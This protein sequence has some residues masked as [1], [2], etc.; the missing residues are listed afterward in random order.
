M[1]DTDSDEE[2]SVLIID[3]GSCMTKVGFSG[4]D[5]PRAV[6][7]TVVGHPKIKS[8]FTCSK[9]Y[10]VGDEAD[11]MQGI[12]NMK[13]MLERGYV[14]DWEDMERIWYHT[15]YNELRVAPEQH[16]VLLA[17]TS[18]SSKAC[19]EKATQIMF[20]TFKI[21]SFYLANQAVLAL[22]ACGKDTGIVVNSGDRI[23]EIVPVYEGVVI[24]HAIKT[25]N[26][27]GQRVTNHL[28]KILMERGH[29]LTT[30]SE[31]LIVKDIKEKMCYV[32]LDFDQEMSIAASSTNFDRSYVLPEGNPISIGNQLFRAPEI[33][34]R[35]AFP[36]DESQGLHETIYDSIM[37]CDASIRRHLFENCV[38]AGG[39]TMFPG[40]AE[41]IHKELYSLGPTTFKVKVIAPPERKY[42][43][44][45]GGSILSSLS[46]FPDV[47]IRKEEY[48]ETGP[49]IIHRKCP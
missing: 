24:P 30:N 1:S 47:C 39:N 43:V 27:A 9:D 38:L 10:Y 19:R 37:S 7:P 13:Y 11:A 6:F 48:E 45:I 41:R 22:N 2:N 49:N 26:F 12:L 5:A 20:E 29:S 3:N 21:P 46:K 31:R 18:F 44:W 14:T 34:F 42:S 40:L 32:A 23:T 33:L 28:S 35:P 36:D 15:F 4:D 16:P 17:Q 25:M 8:S